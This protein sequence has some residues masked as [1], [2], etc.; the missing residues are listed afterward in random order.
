MDQFRGFGVGYDRAHWDRDIDV[1]AV[2]AMPVAALSVGGVAGAKLRV[3]SELKEGIELI[4]G[5]HEDRPA[6][7]P[8][9]SRGSSARDDFLPPELCPPIAT[10]AASYDYSGPISDLHC[11][12]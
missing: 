12:G 6:A 8:I 5:F 9:T 4:G 11:S 7:A 1:P 2:A 3:E 10:V